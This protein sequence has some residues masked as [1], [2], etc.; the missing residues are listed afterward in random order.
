MNGKILT[1]QDVS[2]VGQCSMTVA[3]PILSHF[4]IETVILPTALLSNHTMFKTWS[5][6]DLTPELQNIFRGWS[7]NGF[8]F[9][10]FLLGYLGKKEIMDAA[11]ECFERFSAPGAPVI[12]DPAFGDGGKLYGGFDGEYVS[13]MK[14]LI[15]RADIIIPNLTEVCFLADCEYREEYDRAY[16]ESC[17]KKLSL[18]TG[19]EIVVT[20]VEFGD[21]M[22]GELIYAGGRFEYTFEK[23]LDMRS[24][25]TGDIFAAVFAAYHFSGYKRVESCKKAGQFVAKCIENTEKEHGYGVRFEKALSPID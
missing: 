10:G 5:Y 6:L 14:D 24:H 16:I 21:G 23:K 13:A 8:T 11:K 2:C 1:M 20:G 15:K 19:A 18:I 3:L 22:I 4:G 25:G 12:I 7:E 9:D 17:V